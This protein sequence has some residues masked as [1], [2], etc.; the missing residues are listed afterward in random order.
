MANSDKNIVITPNTGQAATPTIVFTGGSNTPSTLT[1]NDAGTLSFDKQFISSV[2]TGTAPFAVTSTTRVANL[3]VATAGT[4][5]A[6]PFSG[7][8]SKPTTL[9]GYGITNGD[10][11]GGSFGNTDLNTLYTSGTWGFEGSPVN[12]P[13]FIYSNVLVMKERA[14]TIAQFAIDYNSGNAATRGAYLPNGNSTVGAV[15]SP[16]RTLLHNGNFNSYALPLSGGTMTGGITG[17]N[18]T[19]TSFNGGSCT[20]AEYNYILSGGNDT[21]NKLVLF[22]NGST[23]SADG[24]VNAITFRNDGGNLNLGS[25]SYVTNI[26]G[27]SVQANSNII[28]HAGNYTSYSP[29]LTGG[30]AS[31]TWGISITGTAAGLNSSNSIARTGSSGN[32]NTDFS[33]TPAGTMRYQGDDANLTNS[34]GNTWWIYENKRHSNA[35]NQWGVQV[36]WGWEDNA[37]RLATRNVTGGSFGAWVYYL[38]SA[39]YGS[40]A[41][42]LSGGTM[43]GALYHNAA[44]AFFRGGQGVDQCCGDDGAVSVGGNA[45]KPPRIAWHYSGVMEGTIEGSG[46]GWRKI[47]FY[48]QQGSGLGVHATGQIASNVDV[49]AYYSDRRLKTDFEKVTDHWNVLNNI[50]GYRFTWNDKSSEIPGFLEKVGKREVGL[51]AQEVLAV[52]PEAVYTRQEGPEDDPYKTILHDRFNPIFVE[53]LKDLKQ[54]VETLKQENKELLELKKEFEMLKQELREAINGRQSSN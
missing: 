45:T 54:E 30:S 39:N 26:F 52:Y 19:T 34:P 50:S 25:G 38:N 9:A 36:A 28:L 23:R 4:A 22:V 15:W 37:N 29:T 48:D 20:A 32:L 46:T 3:N 43:T 12:G 53:A 13:G 2:A 51:I 1:V 44:T 35:S 18:G 40:Y 5:D 11:S 33:N 17:V 7:I 10:V 21:G 27:S 47:Y 24:G 41:L 14:D 31:G 42:P 49:V 6:V 8:T 16:W